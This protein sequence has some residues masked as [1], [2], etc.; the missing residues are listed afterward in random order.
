[1]SLVPFDWETLTAS[2]ARTGRLV[3][4]DED[5][6]TGCFGQTIVAEMVGTDARFAH[7]LS[8]PK[9]CA[10]ADA[11]VPYHPVLEYA[12]LPDIARVTRAIEETLA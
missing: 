1:V 10:R 11:H 12:I 9:L 8:A 6:R 4:I 3:V 2:I 7:F 5:S